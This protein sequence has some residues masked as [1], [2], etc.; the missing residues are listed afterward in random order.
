[1]VHNVLKIAWARYGSV[2]IAEVDECTLSFIFENK[3]DRDQIMDMSPW[4]VQGHCLNLRVC[5][6]NMCIE[7]LVF[8]T[9]QMWLQIHGLSLDTINEDNAQRM[10]NSLDRCISTESVPIMNHKSYLRIKVD[11]CV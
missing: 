10:G 8:T 4:S 1:M 11:I 6:A 9:M 2:R 5:R 7:D 3:R